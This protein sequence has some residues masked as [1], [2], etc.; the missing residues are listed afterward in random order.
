MS[1]VRIGAG[2]EQSLDHPGAPIG[3]GQREHRDAIVVDGIDVGAGAN[4]KLGRFQIVTMGCPVKRGGTIRLR[5]IH[6]GLLLQQGTHSLLVSPLDRLDEISSGGGKAQGQQC[7][8]P[9]RRQ[10]FHLEAHS[11]PRVWVDALNRAETS[12]EALQ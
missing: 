8:H 3:R 6:I 1:G 10:D 11:R 5:C 12:A 4:Q 2:T 7:D 9:Q